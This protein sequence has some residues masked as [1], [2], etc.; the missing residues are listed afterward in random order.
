MPQFERKTLSEQ[1]AITITKEIRMGVWTKQLPGHRLLGKRYA[2]SRPTCE[3][4]MQILEVNGV[5]GPAEPGKMRRILT[6]R[7]RK[8]ASATLHLLIII[9]SRHPPMQLDAE[10]LIQ[11]E[12]FWRSEGGQVSRMECDLMRS[13][14]PD[15][16][17]KKWVR[18]TG[19]N[20][21]LF[22]TVTY[23]WIDP[24]EKLGFPCYALGGSVPHSN[25]VLSGSGFRISDCIS[26]VLRETLELGHRR[27][28]LVMGRA[29]P[30]KEMRSAIKKATDPILKEDWKGDQISF[31]VK[32]P[33]LVNPS[34]WLGWWKTM[35]RREQPTV[36][37]TESVFQAVCLHNYCLASGIQM[38]RDI[39]IVVL[40][41]ADFLAWLNPL[42][43]RYR[44]QNEKTFR[45]FRDWMRGG[46]PQGSL[47]FFGAKLVGGKTLGP[48]PKDA[49][50][51]PS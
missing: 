7:P 33:D 50:S 25:G 5:V 3:R 35:L 15:F 36:V 2:V 23:D 29:T 16:L 39:S 13:N 47:K 1:L 45:H 27:I 34:D 22:E 49:N 44:Y 8:Q 9:D 19:A 32:I 28:Q 18:M 26:K 11:I 4:A 30:E 12:Q 38:P 31:S 20:C 10:L 46:F 17:L 21:L 42:P 48:V 6:N 41:D 40:E 37:L 14:K 51:N 43:T 24:A